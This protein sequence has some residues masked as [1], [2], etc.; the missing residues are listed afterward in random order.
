MLGLKTFAESPIAALAGVSGNV[1]VSLTG[2]TGTSAVG[3]ATI[4]AVAN[5]SITGQV[6]TGSVGTPV[7][8][9]PI[10]FSI[11]GQA[12]TSALGSATPSASALVDN[13]GNNPDEPLSALTGSIS[14]I[15]VNGSVIAILPNLSATVGSVSVTIDAEANVSIPLADEGEAE[16]GTPVITGNAINVATGQTGTSALGTVTPKANTLNPVTGYEVVSLS[17]IHI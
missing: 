7:I 14:G 13:Y 11:T 2:Q 5:F 6:G 12:G 4:V 3:S 10:V 1:S 15:G 17:L 9:L 16:L 8:S